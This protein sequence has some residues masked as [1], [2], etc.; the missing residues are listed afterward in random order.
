MKARKHFSDLDSVGWSRTEI[1]ALAEKGIV[2]GYDGKFNPQN[3]V[4][5]S[6]FIK[7]IVMSFADLYD[8]SAELVYTDAKTHW[9]DKYVAS[10]H[11][12][13]IING[14]SKRNL[15]VICL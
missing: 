10:A 4:T 15:A 12:H 1:N 6:E 13:G 2:N 3:L 8:S 14:I 9:S 5:R 11:K 7:M